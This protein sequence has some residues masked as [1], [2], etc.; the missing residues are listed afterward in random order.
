MSILQGKNGLQHK[1]IFNNGDLDF[2]RER[3]GSYGSTHHQKEA[4]QSIARIVIPPVA[5]D[6]KDVPL[7][8]YQL[9]SG[10]VK[11]FELKDWDQ[12]HIDYFVSYMN[13][14][15]NALPVSR[16]SNLTGLFIKKG[17]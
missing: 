17:N 7:L 6:S 3:R 15:A 4:I 10:E 16:E 12:D 1:I 11:S 5:V 8:Y 13:M 14:H 2:M 9:K